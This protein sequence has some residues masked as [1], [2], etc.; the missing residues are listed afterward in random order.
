MVCF[1]ITCATIEQLYH[2]LISYTKEYNIVMLL[3]QVHVARHQPWVS[4]VLFLHHYK[5]CHSEYS[6][7]GF[8]SRPEDSNNAGGLLS[9]SHIKILQPQFR[10]H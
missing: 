7:V 3:H 4:V 2:M 8:K 6:L 5:L 10:G 9:V 1:F